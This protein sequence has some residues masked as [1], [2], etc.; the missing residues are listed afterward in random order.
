MSHNFAAVFLHENFS[1]IHSAW[2]L[3]KGW[4]IARSSRQIFRFCEFLDAV[5]EVNNFQ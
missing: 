4:E 3:V 5:N 1:Q 2:F